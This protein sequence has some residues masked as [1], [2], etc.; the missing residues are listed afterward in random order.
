MIYFDVAIRGV[1]FNILKYFCSRPFG[2]CIVP[3]LRA[4]MWNGATIRVSEVVVPAGK[5]A[6]TEE[7]LK[8]SLSH[9]V[10]DKNGPAYYY[11]FNAAD[12]RC[13]SRSCNALCLSAPPIGTVIDSS[14][15]M[16]IDVARDIIVVMVKPPS[17]W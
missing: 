5:W 6:S 7:R 13:K 2:F 12:R 3:Y 4:Y 14:V 1:Y 8:T 10:R 9:S 17:F 15:F 16:R 11:D